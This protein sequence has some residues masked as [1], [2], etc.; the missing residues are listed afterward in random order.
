MSGRSFIAV[1]ALLTTAAC[2]K[3]A[4]KAASPIERLYPAIASARTLLAEAQRPSGD[5][6]PELTR[7][8][9]Y[10]DAQP[11]PQVTATGLVLSVLRPIAE[12]LCLQEVVARASTFLWNQIEPTG[13]VRFYGRDEVLKKAEPGAPPRL[14]MNADLGDT[15]L[16]WLVAMPIER[17]EKFTEM[18][19]HIR[20]FKDDAGMFK[21]WLEAEDT[22]YVKKLGRNPVDVQLLFEVYLLLQG[23]RHAMDTAEQVCDF[24]QK[25]VNTQRYWVWFRNGPLA[26]LLTLYDMDLAGCPLPIDETLLQ[27]TAAEQASYYWLAQTAIRLNRTEYGTLS[28][29]ELTAIAARLSTL[30]QNDFEGMRKH[31]P[32]VFNM[33]VMRGAPEG[34]YWSWPFG[35]AL[36]LRVAE[37]LERFAAAP[38]ERPYCPGLAGYT[39]KVVLK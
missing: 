6:V 10:Q 27:P 5:W 2:T 35:V 36:W 17:R 8:P 4:A 9:V 31:P 38:L 7:Q 32:L 39:S 12:P 33:E 25:N 24:L 23:E 37:R 11:D 21:T 13:L 34:Y 16:T 28:A 30:A 15:A 18:V 3:P 14:A 29:E 19:A 20:Q 22:A 26:P 1:A